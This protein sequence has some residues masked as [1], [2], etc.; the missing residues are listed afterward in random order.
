MSLTRI[1]H[2]GQITIPKRFREILHCD[3][4]DYVEVIMDENTL[5]IVPKE[6][7]DKSQTWFWTKEH[8]EEEAEA[9]MEL[10][11]GMGKQAENAGDLINELNK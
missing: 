8:Q 4:G 1:N 5:R 11:Q 6:L 10:L 2:R 7:I 3:E 9:E